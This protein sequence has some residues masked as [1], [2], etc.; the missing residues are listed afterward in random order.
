MGQVRQQSSTPN[1]AAA[2]RPSR[3]HL[4]TPTDWFRIP[5]RSDPK[6]ERSVAAL[7]DRTYPNRDQHAAQRR[8]LREMLTTMVDRAFRNDGIELYLSTQ[9]VLGVPVPASL[10]VSA[11]PEDPELPAALP[12]KVLADGLWKKHGERAEVT[13]VE[14]PSGPAVRCLRRELSDDAREFGQPVD[15]PAIVLE[16]HV[17]VPGSTAWLLLVFSTP[18]PELADAQ[19]E[20]FD[21]IAASLRWSY[22]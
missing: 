15:R 2:R 12:V 20:M 4:I 17:P 9:A 22:R 18:V 1:K 10:L 19:V 8:E 5:L 16:V 7:V 3:Y 11:E 21:V 6:R 14:L 13:S